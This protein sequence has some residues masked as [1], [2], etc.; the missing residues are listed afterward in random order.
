MS[1]SHDLWRFSIGVYGKPGVAPACLVLQERHRLDINLLLF[2]AWAGAERGHALSD[3]E[4]ARAYA[5]V[6]A[7]HRE[8]VVGIRAIRTRL[9]DGP[10]PAPG[11]ATEPLRS[12]IKKG[13][14][15]AERIEQD[16]L[17]GLADWT[18]AGGDRLQAAAANLANLVDI[19]GKEA[20]IAGDAETATILGACLPDVPAATIAA[21]LARSASIR[22]ASTPSGRG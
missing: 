10:A 20:A 13:E 5:T 11:P 15:D 2:S 7:W 6:G 1:E 4:R 18:E 16:L 17:F 8:M 14:L 9:K 19:D 22:P 12:L 21:A 3:A